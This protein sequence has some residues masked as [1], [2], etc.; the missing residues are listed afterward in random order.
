MNLY[1]NKA[2]MQIQLDQNDGENIVNELKEY[3]STLGAALGYETQEVLEE[4]SNGDMAH[5]INTF[6]KYF[7][8]YIELLESDQVVISR[9]K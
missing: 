3:A 4:M 1:K 5:L 6:T 2:M 8:E 9:D 7:G